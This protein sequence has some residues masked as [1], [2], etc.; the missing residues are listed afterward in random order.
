[1]SVSSE[2]CSVLDSTPESKTPLFFKKKK[3]QD[4]QV[5]YVQIKIPKHLHKAKG[6]RAAYKVTN[7][8]T[9]QPTQGSLLMA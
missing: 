5:V 1:M 7:Q 3:P 2:K 8:S 4:S 9:S 6:S